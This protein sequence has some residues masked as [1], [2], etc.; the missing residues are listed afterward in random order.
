MSYTDVLFI[1]LLACLCILCRWLRPWPRF[2]EWTIVA[3]SL[4]VVASWGVF[5]LLL[6]LAIAAI[7]FVAIALASSA[8][9]QRQRALLIAAIVFDIAALAFFKYAGFV[10]ANLGLVLSVNLGVPA[11]GI[12]LAISFYTFQLISYLVDSLRRRIPPLGLRQYLFYLCFFPHVIAGPIVRV[13][14]LPS[15]LGRIRKLPTDLAFGIHYFVVGFF[16]KAVVAGNLASAMDP[17][18]KNDPAVTLSAADHWIVALLYYCQ[19]YA[20]FAGYSLIA[21]GMARLLGYRL[22]A[23]FR[24]PMLAGTLQD[25]WRRWHITLSRWL[26]DYLYIPLGGNRHGR[27]HALANLM[28]TMLLGGLWH[29]AAWTFVAWGAMHGAG[30]AAERMLGLQAKAHRFWQRFSWWLCTQLWVTLAWVFF[31]AATLTDALAFIRALLRFDGWAAFAVDSRMFLPM[32]IG[33]GAVLHHGAPLA[34]AALPR[35][36]LGICFGAVTAVLLVLDVV[37]YSPNQVFIYFKF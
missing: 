20:D 24:A 22:P 25:F 2:R 14:Q 12:P 3:F 7:N 35:R 11:L 15:Q 26:R 30:L 1:L 34:I 36:Y 28:I 10:A 23:N 21:L 16:L 17:F 4:L 32:L 6:M 18:W 19:I 9:P 37:V 29:G 5:S 33:A 31:R 8:A 13:W 27:Y